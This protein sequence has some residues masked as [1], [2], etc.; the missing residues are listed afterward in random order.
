[1]GREYG[2]YDGSEYQHQPTEEELKK[3]NYYDILGVSPKATST[4]IK[5]AYRDLAVTHHPDKHGGD[6]TMFKF[7]SMAYT[8]LSSPSSRAKHDRKYGMNDFA[9]KGSTSGADSGKAKN[10]SGSGKETKSESKDE[11]QA[12]EEARSQAEAER[13]RA[14]A[15]E[16]QKQARDE[17]DKER[18]RKREAQEEENRRKAESEEEK[19]SREHEKEVKRQQEEFEARQRQEQERENQRQ[20]RKPED[21][22]DSKTKTWREILDETFKKPR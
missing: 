2:G 18:E 6:D 11:S 17:A 3:K 22:Y 10:E 13:Q 19:A 21:G 5:K 9:P 12:R 7:I 20:E 15:E 1:M 14:E 4:E 16:K 8:E